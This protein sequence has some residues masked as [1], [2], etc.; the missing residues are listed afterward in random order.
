MIA[1]LKTYAKTH[2]FYIVLIAVGLIA[3]RS[4]LQEHDA[5]L[6][7]D[8]TVKQQ[9]I[10]VADL[11]QQIVIANQQAAQKVQVITKVVHDA[12]TPTQVV[13]AI[14]SLTSLP[15]EAREIPDD[16]VN[17]AVAAQPLIQLAG[18]DKACHIQLDACQQVA[19][20]KDQQ[21]KAKDVEIVA[22]KKKPGFWKRVSGKLKVVGIGVG[23]GLLL[24]THL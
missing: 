21:L 14:P 10:V 6:K 24:S 12:V 8:D 9:E 5:R 15:L 16:P 11:K 23:I 17:V 18:D 3:F 22:L 1:W 2:L 19:S 13:A 4:W 20:L 7:A